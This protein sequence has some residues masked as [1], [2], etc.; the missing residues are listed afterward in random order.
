MSRLREAL[1]EQVG[2]GGAASYEGGARR[3]SDE[4][5]AVVTLLAGH[6]SLGRALSDPG[7]EADA[8]VRLVDNLLGG[9]VGE[10]VLELVRHTARSRWSEPRDV[11][12][13]LEAVAV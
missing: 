9:K 4:M 3:L 1:T 10:P 12:D 13:A 6:G 8:K 5:F 11:V 2:S 7:I